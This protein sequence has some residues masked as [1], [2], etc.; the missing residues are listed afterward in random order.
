MNQLSQEE[1]E[2]IIIRLYWD[3]KIQPV[4]LFS[5]LN[6]ETYDFD[7]L[8]EMKFYRRLLASCDW[9]T[10][11]KLIPLKKIRKE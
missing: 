5:L 2:K 3:M 10:L 11:L 4:H 6:K 7:D 1:K 9:Y 8:N